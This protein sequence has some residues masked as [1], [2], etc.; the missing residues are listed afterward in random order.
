MT[1]ASEIKFHSHGKISSV[2]QNLAAINTA[3]T[4]SKADTPPSLSPKPDSVFNKLYVT[5]AS[6]NATASVSTSSIKITCLVSRIT[7]S[8]SSGAI[9]AVKSLILCSDR[10][11]L[12]PD[13]QQ[14]NLSLLNIALSL[15]GLFTVSL[16]GP[17]YITDV[18]LFN[19]HQSAS[20]FEGLLSQ[21]FLEWMKLIDCVILNLKR[22]RR[23][24]CVLCLT[25]DSMIA[26]FI[27]YYIRHT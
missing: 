7:I 27:I 2:E 24:Y 3:F 19:Q 10:I 13:P 8:L 14:K 12:V 5:S 17:N 21:I 26:D 9:S 18:S 25:A 11:F 23:L 16:M 22:K 1:Q 4:D 6:S 15:I 20:V